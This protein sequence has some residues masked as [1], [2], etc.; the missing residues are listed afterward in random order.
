ME[1]NEKSHNLETG[2]TGEDIASQFLE[3][4]GY[5]I[6]ARN[7]QAGKVEIDLIC[8]K[9]KLLVFVE[10]KSRFNALVQPENAVDFAK[11]RNLARAA[12]IYLFKNKINDPI[13]FDIIAINFYHGK[14]DIAHFEDAFY[15]V[16]YK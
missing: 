11:Q 16:F 8:M 4:K 1:Q 13:Q 7:Y 10:V 14:V 12:E 3:K 9:D 15:P 6:I 5:Q 2:R